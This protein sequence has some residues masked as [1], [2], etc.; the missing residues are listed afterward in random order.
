MKIFVLGGSGATG[1]LLVA[2]LLAAGHKVSV[3]VRNTASIPP[4]WA[5]QAGLTLIQGN[6]SEKV[7]RK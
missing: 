4:S 5:K 3:M 6:I 7:R 2:Q 1:K